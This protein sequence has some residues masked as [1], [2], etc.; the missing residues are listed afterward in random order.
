MKEKSN[1]GLNYING[2]AK[3]AKKLITNNKNIDKK[4]IFLYVIMN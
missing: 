1:S 4:K 2:L 3:V